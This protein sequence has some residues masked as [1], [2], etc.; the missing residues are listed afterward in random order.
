M[1]MNLGTVSVISNVRR[2]QNEFVKTSHGLVVFTH[3]YIEQLH[4]NP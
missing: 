3:K 1:V 4:D 2:G